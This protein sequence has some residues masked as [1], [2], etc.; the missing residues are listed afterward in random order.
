MSIPPRYSEVK[1][2]STVVP[3]TPRLEFTLLR[4]DPDREILVPSCRQRTANDGRDSLRFV[5][6]FSVHEKT[7]TVS[8]SETR[9]DFPC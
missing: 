4:K 9:F 1:A 3:F 6:R 5:L 8:G 2:A 7:V